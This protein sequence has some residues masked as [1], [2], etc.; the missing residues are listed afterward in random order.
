MNLREEPRHLAF[1][2]EV[3]EFLKRKLPEKLRLHND[4]AQHATREETLTWQRILYE[5]GWAAPHWP[6]EQGGTGWSAEERLIF[7]IECS[8]AG[9]PWI[10]QQGIA[11]VGPIV[12]AFGTPEQKARFILPLLRGEIY[13]CQGFSEPS[14]GSDLASL[15]T[16]ARKEEGRYYVSGQKIW[17]SHAHHADWIFMLVRTE[18]T[19]K[20]QEGISFL[21]APMNTPGIVV[22]QLDC[23]DGLEHLC[24]VFFD[25]VEIP[26]DQL[27]GQEGRGW[28]IAKYLLSNERVSGA[29]DLPGMLRDL[30]RLKHAVAHVASGSG[31]RIDDP[32]I[33]LRVA[34][35]SMG[36]DAALMSYRRAI[37]SVN[38]STEHN[39]EIGNM[40]KVKVTELHQQIVELL[41]DVMAD[42]GPLF[43]PSPRHTEEFP[44]AL[45]PGL[46]LDLSKVASEIMYRRGVS[47]HGGTNE[48]QREIIAKS[49]YG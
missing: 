37:A 3:R 18:K 12:N 11:L 23:I 47:I 40:L 16:F 13:W 19:P 7:D 32:V 25:N 2:S 42:R 8:A 43:Y 48:I 45:L 26:A 17:T 28:S 14:S 35:V 46:D 4:G 34:Q 6:K 30:G 5:Q 36:A 24:E 10:N 39:P 44:P 20:K 22:R 29:C 21:V 38:P 9:A 15:R 27:I 1:Q 31:R 33:A 41:Y 49:I